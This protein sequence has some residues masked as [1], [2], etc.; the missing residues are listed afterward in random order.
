MTA[1]P[2]S[3]LSLSLCPQSNRLPSVSF[4]RYISPI[5]SPSPPY[6]Q[7]NQIT[8]NCKSIIHPIHSAASPPFSPLH[9]L[10]L[11][12]KPPWLAFCSTPSTFLSRSISALLRPPSGHNPVCKLQLSPN[13]SLFSKLPC[14][15][16]LGCA[17]SS[18]LSVSS[19]IPCK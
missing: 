7:S 5:F 18:S 13:N 4:Q 19:L 12:C 11:P 17:F 3:T 6:L 10:K 16:T 9:P 2:S 14:T 8:N 15:A 1:P